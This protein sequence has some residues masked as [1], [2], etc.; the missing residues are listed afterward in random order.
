M[1]SS[2]SNGGTGTGSVI[3]RDRSACRLEVRINDGMFVLKREASYA[4]TT[5]I[6]VCMVISGLSPYHWCS[7]WHGS[8]PSV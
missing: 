3:V 2:L 5:K 1:D 6:A 8:L 4:H 7:E